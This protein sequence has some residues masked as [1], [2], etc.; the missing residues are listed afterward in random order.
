MH[1]WVLFGVLLLAFGLRFYLAGATTYLWDEERDWVLLADSISF[2]PGNWNLPIRGDYHGALS[3]YFI[4]FSSLLFGR[5]HIGFRLVGLISGLMTIVVLARIAQEWAGTTAALWTTVLMAFNEYHV[6][7]SVLAITN[8]YHLFFASCALYA[9]CRFL[10]TQNPKNLYL[11]AVALGAAFLTYEI[12]LLFLPAFFLAVVVTGNGSWL[13]R[14]E[15]YL[16]SLLF[17]I[18]I[19]PDLYWNLNS[20]GN[21]ELNYSDHLGRMG[22][23][24]VSDQPLYFYTH[25]ILVVT[26]KLM[27]A[28]LQDFAPEFVGMNP[29]FGFIMLGS[30]IWLVIRSRR[31]VTVAKC[32]LVCLWFFFL[33]F[34]FI[35]PGN[36]GRKD[37]DTNL[38]IWV[39]VT[40][41][42]A[43]VL[44]GCAL[45]RLKGW[46]RH[47]AVA[48]VALACLYSGYRLVN[49]LYTMPTIA[50]GYDP[51]AFGAL[52]GHMVSIE[53][54][55]DY[56]DFCDGKPQVQL[57]NIRVIEK[58]ANNKDAEIPALESGSVEGAQL[59]TD[60]RTFAL[61]ATGKER[62]RRYEIFW[63]LTDANGKVQNLMSELWV[64]PLSNPKWRLPFWVR[65]ELIVAKKQ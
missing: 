36:K 37:L 2:S 27:G 54:K 7:H 51:E 9:F 57:L 52:D 63:R 45:S 49:S 20:L 35:S 16:A 4:K 65:N 26:Y 17:L 11:A 55:F 8:F 15:T 56:C 10:R 25:P 21:A 31:E 48:V 23:I 61:R 34:S 60:D 1:D 19:V 13:K 50:V 47:V 39:D 28:K 53:T 24:G 44:A 42:P 14:K 33:F 29:L 58:E 40:M 30:A 12:A 38:W 6:Q 3:A 41:L 5:S 59:G 62:D 18:V 43:S 32:L 46:W 22:G 64:R